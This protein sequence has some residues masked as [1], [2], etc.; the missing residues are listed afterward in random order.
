[1]NFLSFFTSAILA[2]AT[3]AQAN[4]PIYLDDNVAVEARVED[5]LSRMTLE[6][7]VAVIHAQSKF[8]SAGVPRLG[9]PDVWTSDGPFGVRED[10]L[11][12]SF[13][14]AEQ[15]NDSCTC[16]PNLPCLAA[17][18]NREMA[19]KYG[20]NV[21]EEAKYRRKTVML[22]PG[23]NIFRTPL[24]GRNFEYMGEDP[25]LAAQM[26]VPY[27]RNVQKHGVASCAKHFAL[28]NQEAHRHTVE[29]VVDERTLREIYLPA[30]EASVKDAGVWSIMG[31]YN[32]YKGQFCC[33]N[34]YL[35]VD[36]L[37]D[38]WGFDGAVIS[39]WGG[40][41]DM[42]QSIHNGL[43]MEFGT[44]T[45]GL[46]EGDSNAYDRYC[47]SKEY[48]EGLRAG[49]YDLATLDDKVRRVL[50][51][52]FRTTM[53]PNKSYGSLASP[54]HMAV[55][56]EIAS[57]GVVLLKNDG[58]TLP[59]NLDGIKKILVV[60]DNATALHAHAGGSMFLKTKYEIS[61]LEGL[62][63]LVGDKAEIVFERGYEPHPMNENPTA[64]LK[65]LRERAAR[66]AADA[67]VVLFFGG[68]N[69]WAFQDCEGLDKL[70]YD[71]PYSQNELIE[72]LAQAN[73]NIV[74]TLVSGTAMPMPW[75]D[76]VPAVVYGWY[77]G[78]EGGNVLADIIFG[79]V[80]PSGHMP[81]TIAHKLSDY[82][83]HALGCYDASN[84]GKV[85]Y[86]EGIYNGYR[87]FEHYGAEPLFPFGHGMSYTQF[88][89]TN[90][91]IS[92]KV[93]SRGKL[94][95]SVDVR[96]VGPMRGAEVVQLYIKDVECSAARPQKEL[97]NFE[98]VWLDPGQKCT[99]TM[100][101]R[102][103]DLRFFDTDSNS[104]RYENGE[105]QVLLGASS[106][107]IRFTLPFTY[108]DGVDQTC[109]DVRELFALVE[110]VC[111]SDAASRVEFRL[112][113][114]SAGEG[115][116]FTIGPDSTGDKVLI[117]AS[118]ASAA[119][120][121]LGWYLNHYAHV[122]ICWNM[123]SVKLPASDL[124]VPSKTERRSA[125]DQMR[126]YLN[127]CTYSYSMAFWNWERWQ[128]EIDWMALH[129]VNMPLMLVGAD[130]VWRGV[131]Q[132]L[133]YSKEE[134]NKFIA[135]PGFQAWWLMNNLQGWGGPNPDWWYDRQL[136][137]S[138]KILA[139]M[140]SLGMTPVLPG[141]CGMVPRDAAEKLGLKVEDPGKWC[142]VFDRPAFLSPSD[143]DF[144]RI[145]AIYYKNLKRVMGTSV[146]YSMD[147]FH[148]GGD[149]SGVDLSA[150]Y[151]AINDAMHKAAPAAKWVLQS[152]NE[153]P[154]KE[155]LE[156]IP[157]GD[158]IVLDLFSDGDPKWMDGYSGHE[159][160]YCMLNNFGGRM[161]LHG[162]L[163]STMKGY[164]DAWK[165]YPHTLFGVGATP[166]GLETNTV[167]YD[168][169]YELPWLREDECE[170]WLDKYLLARYGLKEDDVLARENVRKAWDILTNTV[171][172]CP[173]K[174]QGVSESVV[175][176]KPAFEVERASS[177]GTCRL[178][179]DPK[180]LVEALDYMNEAESVLGAH[181]N[182]HWD[183]SELRRQVISDSC[184]V[185]LS[186]AHHAYLRKDAKA[187]SAA[188][189][190]F[191]TNILRLDAIASEFPSTDYEHV[192]RMARGICDGYFSDARSDKDWMEWNLYTQI[193][194]WSKPSDTVES[195]LLD[196]SNR[197]WGGLLR[198]YYYPRWEAFF[199]EQGSM[200]K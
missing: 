59:L 76:K 133:G 163:R 2:C 49:K 26:A 58:Y 150:A 1:M 171:L 104:W 186:Q 195:G 142:A 144:A 110:R 153:N 67:D 172:D 80:C 196:Y 79:K 13:A 108:K 60:G 136:D 100:T 47:L 176:A 86:A 32:K 184:Q 73:P 113:D 151:N 87:G 43:D 5:A 55:A 54:E 17:T 29:P 183:I 123:P 161:G 168:A 28:N 130:C 160:M 158:F 44:W 34:K 63:N 7:K 48:L 99:V 152:W 132:E 199:R 102:E 52:I 194:T 27:I 65:E 124:P 88:E 155:A 198:D 117:T 101:V 75:L 81:F 191:L 14:S 175:C 69:R 170:G 174:Q 178:Y 121:G 11:W 190:K 169:L 197:L 106:S 50:R 122:N 116:V 83:A 182:F 164:F 4:M 22:G 107:D 109:A 21:G 24:C 146:Y 179:Y 162:R 200:L 143:K 115:D 165:Q 185:L 114:P 40:A 95:V 72:A 188:T 71:L 94:E 42:E 33:H 15:S 149:V 148:E 18:F 97:K 138:R 10:A 89:W 192:A 118:S 62:K 90:P 53:G 156:A 66:A 9:I 96:N 193:T 159:F 180:K 93:M 68:H 145:A 181:P 35:L 111:G 120:A 140:R 64:R 173:G 177:W 12:D 74:V 103:E 112:T 84:D 154:R 137:L 37:K 41:T 8:T 105:Y 125:G 46:T 39:D 20:N 61:P 131:L 45:D 36:I 189:E 141:Y 38:E 126:Y 119:G 128:Q 31:A 16:N 23:M 25:Y 98:K 77:G 56:R 6:E 57:E 85:Y 157:A 19:A 127:Y 82:P 129:G 51:L 134:C 135:G 91:R 70:I 78:S 30:F 187:Y 3:Q 166:E 92:R 139:R 147:P 167:L